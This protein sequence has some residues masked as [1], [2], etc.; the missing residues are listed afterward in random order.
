MTLQASPPPLDARNADDVVAQVGGDLAATGWKGATGEPGWALVR[1][2]GRLSELVIARLNQVPDKHFL[3]F[4]N[5]AGLDL[6]PPRPASSELTFTPAKDVTGALEVPAGTQV[7]TKQTETQPEVVFETLR[8]LVVSP[9]A[10][11]K[12]V[13]FD[14]L[15]SADRTALATGSTSDSSFAVFTGEAER[16]RILYLGDS[17]LFS[18]PDAATRAAAVVN[19]SFELARPGNPLADGW[20]LEWLIWNGSLWSKLAEGSQVTDGTAGFSKQNGVVSLKQL[21]EM[22]ENGVTGLWLACKLTGGAGRRHLPVFRGVT[23]T[24]T[25]RIGE[26]TAVPDAALSAVN[27][28]TTFVPADPTG[29]FFPLG[30]FPARLDTFYLRVD[31]AFSKPGVNV[32]LDMSLTGLPKDFQPKDKSLIK[33]L[34]I[35]WDYSTS[36]GWCQLGTSTWS[37]DSSATRLGFA[38]ATRALTKPGIV[39]WRVPG[40]EQDKDEKP[41]AKTTVNGQEGYWVRARINQG[42][43]EQPGGLT[44]PLDAKTP[45]DWIRPVTYAPF[46]T[47]LVVKYANYQPAASAPKDVANRQGLVDGMWRDHSTAKSDFAPF[48]AAEEGPALNLGFQPGFPA[49]SWIQLLLDVEEPEEGAEDLPAIFWEYWN[50]SEWRGLR[51]SDGTQGLQAARLSR[52]LRAG[53]PPAQHRVRAGGL[54]AARPAVCLARSCCG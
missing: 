40:G 36:D 24:R 42:D 16:E 29:E 50:G 48:S 27:A 20:K 8:D 25:I 7:A 33:S 26:A 44:T 5:E 51:A 37:A 9:A 46:V 15:T 41:F 23:G 19:L 6:L 10:L 14:P 21:P 45:P 30:Q 1:L 22:L 52:L 35:T 4:L 11:V 39:T 2:F 18:F 3:A 12:V 38:D 31:E 54:L 32:T 53:R 34:E 13:V 28:G 47:S 17:E 43:Y 49:G